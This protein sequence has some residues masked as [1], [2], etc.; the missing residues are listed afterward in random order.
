MFRKQNF[1]MQTTGWKFSFEAV[2][3]SGR[4]RRRDC[5]Q[6]HLVENYKNK[7]LLWIQVPRREKNKSS[8]EQSRN[9]SSASAC[10]R[11]CFEG[12]ALPRSLGVESPFW[13]SLR[14]A[15]CERAVRGCVGSLGK[16]SDEGRFRWGQEY[17]K[18]EE[19]NYGKNIANSLIT[20][21]LQIKENN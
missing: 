21:F 15:T 10:F 11:G 14:V 4:I 16:S 2:F 12:S 18:E 1:Q 8:A 7:S 17:F 3:T 20:I 5:K 6:T 13:Q 9:V 19:Q